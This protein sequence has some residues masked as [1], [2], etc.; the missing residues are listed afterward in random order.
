V[1]FVTRPLR[2]RRGPASAW[3]CAAALALVAL[4]LASSG[5]GPSG[6]AVATTAV[7][8]GPVSGAP[9]SALAPRTAAGATGLPTPPAVPLSAATAGDV[10]ATAYVNYNT[11]TA[12][13]FPGSVW[14]WQ[15]G[16]AAVDPATDELWIPT[17]PVEN[18]SVEP[19][20][21]SPA[22]VY[23]P[24]TN[25]TRTVGNLVDTSAFAFDPVNGY[26]YATDPLN[27]TV[28]VYNAS[29]DAWVRSALPVGS[30]PV[31]IAYDPGTHHLFVANEGSNNVTVLNATTNQVLVPGI[32]VG[33]APVALADDTSDDQVYSAN[34]GSSNL[35]RISTG[36]NSPLSN[37][38]TLANPTSLSWSESLDKLA[39]GLPTLAS[40]AVLNAATGSFDSGPVVGLGVSSVSTNLSGTEFVVANNSGS[41]LTTVDATSYAVSSNAVVVRRNPQL[42]ITDPVSGAIYSWSSTSRSITIASLVTLHPT[43]L[44]PDLGPR[45]SALAFDPSSNQVLSLDRTDDAVD[46]LSASTFLSTRS[47]LLLPAAP[48]SIVDDNSTSTVYVG[49]VGGIVGVDPVSGQIVDANYSLAG[50]NTDLFVDPATNVLWDLNSVDGLITLDLPS[51]TGHLLIGIGAGT[52]NVRGIAFDNATNALFVDVLNTT[53]LENSTIHVLNATTGLQAL[54]TITDVPYVASVAYDP[55]DQLL[56]AL[57]HA[58]WI[59]N[60][61]TGAIVAGPVA[62]GPNTVAWSLTYDPSREF[63]YAV[64]TDAPAY[65]G[66]LTVIDGASIALSEGPTVTIPV[67]QLPFV[68]VPVSLPGSVAPGSGEIWVGNEGSGTI[69]IIASAPTVEYFAA[70]PNPVDANS[71]TRVLLGLVGGAG[72]STVSYSGLPSSCPSANALNLSC[73]PSAPGS[74]SIEATVID[75][76]GHSTTAAT[77]LSVD[78]ALG[79][80][81]EFSNGWPVYVDVGDVLDA[82]ASVTG[83]TTGVTYSWSFGDGTTGSGATASHTYLD[84]GAYLVT[85]DA[86]DAGGGEVGNTTLVTVE[87]LP[88]VALASDP[89]NATDVGLPIAFAATVSGGTTPG[90]ATWS[91]G[92]GTNASGTGVEHM[93][94][95]PGVYFATFRYSDRSGHNASSYLTIQV[96]PAL[97]AKLSV[98]PSSSS[99]STGTAVE[100]SA[101]VSG[102]TAPYTIVWGFDDGSYAYG[103]SSEHT[104]ATTGTYTV[105]LFVEDAAGGQWNTTYRL[106]VQP[107]ST[108][109]LGTSFV[110]GIFL[111]VVAG[112]AVGAVVLF[113][114]GRTRRS[115][116]P[117]PTPYAPSPA[118]PESGEAEPTGT[119]WDEN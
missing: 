97:S 21:P 81:V 113:F 76:L 22:I 80:T 111:G 117:P 106:S 108:S 72:P 53:N 28:A 84:P 40:L 17:L 35:T 51:L 50:N 47:P 86:S 110:Q 88:T 99:V 109:L 38:G 89:A 33:T 46:F 77:L 96:N 41:H 18:A 42:L 2:A 71:S 43:Q 20:G 29:T 44:A 58:I 30:D 114:A 10:V 64:T 8:R 83:G 55:A 48:E 102:G 39:V 91:F 13:N 5:A 15:V 49:L 101:A 67:G 3:A 65:A 34:S 60:P 112:A 6:G 4:L 104:Y 73:T 79:L 32:P 94:S 68:A 95:T 98:S 16:L 61:S 103:V 11:T 87:P 66:N 105:T 56:Y 70:S 45:P 26:L 90:A 52:I 24:A 19:S 23:D 9:S 59:L 115:H 75:S 118:A 78:P 25:T 107:P 93:Y 27:D 37:P 116:P 74:Y 63:L 14:N 100:F 62:I 82:R 119:A 7:G 31:A 92:D 54:P 12:G 1:S 69:S 36:S 57:G 85:V